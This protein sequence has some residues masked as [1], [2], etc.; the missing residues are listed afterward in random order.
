M[1]VALVWAAPAAGAAVEQ[2][3]AGSCSP[4]INGNGNHIHLGCGDGPQVL[5]WL[6][7]LVAQVIE[8]KAQL[9]DLRRQVFSASSGTLAG[10]GTPVLPS[11]DWTKGLSTSSTILTALGTPVLPNTGP[12]AF[13]AILAGPG[14]PVLPSTDW[15]KGLI[16]LNTP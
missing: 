1:I 3:T 5:T 6:K 9:A 16:L 10:P 2:S 13:S 11:T 14:A 12:S 4:A 15:T 7:E 8:L